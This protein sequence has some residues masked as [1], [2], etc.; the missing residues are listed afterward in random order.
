L[1]QHS[2]GWLSRW[3]FKYL[4]SA[5][6]ETSIYHIDHKADSH[7][8]Q[9]WFSSRVGKSYSCELNPIAIADQIYADQVDILIDLDS[10]TYGLTPK[11]MACKAAPV[12]V[13]WLGYDSCGLPGIDYFIADPYVLPEEADAYYAEKIWRLSETY[14]AVDGFE[15]GIPT[16]RRQDF[17]IPDDAI[18][19][20]SAQAGLKRHPDTVRLQLQVLKEVPGSYLLVKGYGDSELVQELFSRIALEIEID[21]GRIKFLPR[22]RDEFSHRANLQIADVILD[23]YPYNGATTTLEALWMGVPIVT[24][25]GQQFAARNSYAFLTNAGITQGIAWTDQEYVDWGIRLGVDK[26]LRE[27]LVA[28]LQKS[29]KNAPLWNTRKFTQEMEKAFQQMW[30]IYLDSRA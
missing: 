11:V 16:L 22:D 2:V 3:L 30:H 27:S 15:V 29:R 12:Q 13:T 17:D 26:K 7:F 9:C 24:R 5:L 21:P 1:K 28:E 10:N 20:L 23:T 25:V 14:I 18:I 19:Y 8:T 6:F 4:N